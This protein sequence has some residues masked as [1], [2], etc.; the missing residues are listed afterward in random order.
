MLSNAYQA[1]WKRNRKNRNLCLDC[2]NPPEKDRVRC[3]LCAE[4]HRNKAREAYN[5]IGAPRRGYITQSKY[6]TSLREA[7]LELYGNKCICCG[8]TNKKYLELDHI[9]N[10]GNLHRRNGSSA[11]YRDILTKGSKH[12][13]QLLCA[14]CHR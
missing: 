6:R 8:Q 12:P 1:T 2:K 4:H 14:N 7:I 10:D 5:P 3:A 9:N 13:I 11:Y